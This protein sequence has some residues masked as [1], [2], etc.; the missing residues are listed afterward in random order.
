MSEYKDPSVSERVESLLSKMTL[1]EKIAQIMQLD[2]SHDP[3]FG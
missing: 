3:Q 2:I 1:S